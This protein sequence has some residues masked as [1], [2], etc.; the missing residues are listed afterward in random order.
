[1]FMFPLK[2][3]AQLLEILSFKVL[4]KNR[5]LISCLTV[6][7]W[8]YISKLEVSIGWGETIC[9]WVLAVLLERGWPAHTLLLWHPDLTWV[10]PGDGVTI[11]E[12]AQPFLLYL[13]HSQLSLKGKMCAQRIT[14]IIFRAPL[15]CLCETFMSTMDEVVE[16]EC[17]Y[18]IFLS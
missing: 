15:C 6:V 14:R 17:K 1:M 3:W 18:P 5:I 11:H 4:F 8:F 12:Q 10:L 16:T 7:K 9:Q 13:S 2:S